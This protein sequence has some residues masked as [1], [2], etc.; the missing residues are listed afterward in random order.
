M[1]AV[2]ASLALLLSFGAGY[3][4]T[5]ADLGNTYV[6]QVSESEIINNNCEFIIIQI[7][8]KS[9]LYGL[10]SIIGYSIYIDFN[11]FLFTN[12]EI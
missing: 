9:I 7:I 2:A 10:F 6:A 11:L 12:T 5:E 8:K 3:M 4:F 1:Y